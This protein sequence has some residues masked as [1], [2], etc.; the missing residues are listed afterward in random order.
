MSTAVSSEHALDGDGSPLPTPESASAVQGVA[1]VYRMVMPGHVC[2]FGLKSVDLLKRRGFVVDD[3]WIRTR[4]EQERV[5]SR[6]HVKSTPQV[7][8]DGKRIGGWDDLRRHFGIRVRDANTTSYIPVAAVFA[9]A[10][11]LAFASAW[12]TGQI[13]DAHLLIQRFAATAMCLLAMLKLQ[14]IE[15]FTSMFLNYDLLGK[16]VVRYAYFYPWA[17]FGAGALMLAGVGTMLAAM[18]ALFVGTVGAISVVKA[19]YV[20]RRELKCACVGG[21]SSIPLGFVSLTENLMMIAM[22][23]WMATG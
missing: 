1:V 19:V 9:T 6:W 15:S 22:G 10:L 8:I 14:D 20:D 4:E 18:T 5:K 11:T 3:R 17:E 23:V 13:G 2:P 21:G 12:T 16:R 7:F